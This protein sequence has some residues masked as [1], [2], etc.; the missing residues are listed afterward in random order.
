MNE[1]GVVNGMIFIQIGEA[2]VER[3]PTVLL[4]QSSMV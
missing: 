4:V 3:V 1:F 2:L